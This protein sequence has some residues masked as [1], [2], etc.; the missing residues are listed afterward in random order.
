MKK[1]ISDFVKKIREN[2]NFL[3]LLFFV[4]I[5]LTR[6]P[7]IIILESDNEPGFD[8]AYYYNSAKNINEGNGEVTTIKDKWYNNWE[9]N[10]GEIETPYY[11][12]PLYVY[13]LAL[14][15]KISS[16]LLAIR[17]F[18]TALMACSII[19]YYLLIKKLFN[20]DIAIFSS[21]LLIINPLYYLYSISLL[22]ESL[23]ILIY[24]TSIY[25]ITSP[26]NNH[27]S[28]NLIFSGFF[29]GL[30]FLA[31]L[32]GLFLVLSI[33]IWLFFYK[34]KYKES[35]TFVLICV[36]TIIP[37]LLNNYI[38]HGFIFP[39]FSI[40]SDIY[41]A[42]L[43]VSYH[44]RT[45]TFFAIWIR[46]E[47][48]FV[49]I[50][51]ISGLF[52]LMPFILLGMFRNRTNGAVV[53]FI[54]FI[55][56]TLMYHVG[57]HYVF[58]YLLPIIP[59]CLPLG[60]KECLFY[61]EKLKKENYLDFKLNPKEMFSIFLILIF[62]ANMFFIPINLIDHYVSR[63]YDNNQ[64]KYEWIEDTSYYKIA[65]TSPQQTNYFTER[66][67][68]ILDN[69]HNEITLELFIDEYDFDLLVF[70][71]HKYGLYQS[72]DFLI[73]FFD[74]QDNQTF[75][76]GKYELSLLEIKEGEK[77]AIKFFGVSKT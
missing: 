58:R 12:A 16:S 54:I 31:R 69:K 48:F 36:V 76:I 15:F 17:I 71:D 7:G 14:L 47:S 49:D 55:S 72:N 66:D 64:S 2:D 37:W 3:F 1:K 43:E 63:Y 23:Y 13:L 21:F 46:I 67:T 65:S 57:H 33:F 35:L 6:I 59:L 28:K 62:L 77:N 5:V 39:Y 11:L 53:L 25:F 40:Y 10:R 75:I 24:L 30:S 74:A 61:L 38:N 4:I 44:L 42:N 8:G 9:D 60:I 50:S 29:A 51:S 56:I 22:R 41:P 34:R 20:R 19:V 18:N 70:D 45:M 73:Q 27:K 52:I 68:V 26:I 32:P